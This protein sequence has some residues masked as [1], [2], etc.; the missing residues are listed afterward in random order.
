[1][2]RVY[3]DARYLV[4]K[5][6]PPLL[7][8]QVIHVYAMTL[9]GN[10][11]KFRI[12]FKCGD[13]RCEIE[14]ASLRALPDPCTCGAYPFP[15]RPGSGHCSD[16]GEDPGLCEECRYS[17]LVREPFD[18]F[19]APLVTECAIGDCPWEPHTF[20]INLPPEQYDD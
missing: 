12:L 18:V 1:M 20:Q 6:S 13:K 19:G 15:H 9:A 8:G 5:D 4:T 14:R 10:G 7:K 2:R 11:R 16:P 17:R 3:P